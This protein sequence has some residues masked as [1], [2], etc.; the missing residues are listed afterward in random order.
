MLKQITLVTIVCVAG[1][2]PAQAAD[3]TSA[4]AACRTDVG[5]YCAGVEKGDGRILKCLKEYRD[6]LSEG[7]KTALRSMQEKR[8]SMAKEKEAVE[9]K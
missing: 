6:S 3:M 1:G 4:Q 7:C 2:L 9:V 8:Q 5:V